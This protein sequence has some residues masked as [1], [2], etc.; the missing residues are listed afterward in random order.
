LKR[1][2]NEKEGKINKHHDDDNEVVQ[3]IEKCIF[4]AQSFEQG[5]IPQLNALFLYINF[6]YFFPLPLNAMSMK[7]IT[8]KYV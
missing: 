1:E 5:F 8:R 7:I 3:H 6:S 2:Q 4:I